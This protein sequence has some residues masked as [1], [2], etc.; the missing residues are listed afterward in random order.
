MRVGIIRGLIC[1]PL[2]GLEEVVAI[3]VAG[4]LLAWLVVVAHIA[5][6]P[7]TP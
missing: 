2:G 6:P 1:R 7:A 5:A 3:A 4:V